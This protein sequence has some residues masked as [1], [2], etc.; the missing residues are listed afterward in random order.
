VQA[1]ARTIHC[2]LLTDGAALCALHF[3]RCSTL[4]VLQASA[5]AGVHGQGLVWTSMLSTASNRGCAL[6][7]LM[8]KQMARVNSH[9]K[10][11]Y[12]TLSARTRSNPGH[13]RRYAVLHSPPIASRVGRPLDAA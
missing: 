11:D 13:A 2:T 8:P 3:V 9:S 5:I 10:Y 1:L 6:L 12:C 4:Q 7:E